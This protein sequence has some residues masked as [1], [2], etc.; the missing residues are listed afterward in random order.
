ML[1]I[2][3]PRHTPPTAPAR[4]NHA[5]GSPATTMLWVL[6]REPPLGRFRAFPTLKRLDLLVGASLDDAII[7]GAR[8]GLAGHHQ[9][10]HLR[11]SPR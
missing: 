9:I 3:R 10:R 7:A 11:P 4:P 2:G 5:Y 6:H 1:E 8:G